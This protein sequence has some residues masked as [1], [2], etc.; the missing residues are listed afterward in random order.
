MYSR[1]PHPSLTYHAY[2]NAKEIW[3]RL[4]AHFQKEKA[5]PKSLIG[6][7]FFNFRL[8]ANLSVTTQIIELENLHHKLEDDQSKMDD[9]IFVY[10][11]LS[12]LPPE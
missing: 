7:K 1:N 2:K 12:K 8:K 6:E 11:I 9:N 4:D 5:L 3:V 10:L